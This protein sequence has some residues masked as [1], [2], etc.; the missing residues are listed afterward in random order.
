MAT[1]STARNA[2]DVAIWLDTDAGMA[3]GIS[4]SMASAAIDLQATL[5]EYQ[6]F[7]DCC[8]QRLECGVDATITLN[9]LY[10]TAA[11]EGRDILS[12]WW[13]QGCSKDARTLAIY[14][15]DKNVGSEKWSG[16]FRLEG[17]SFGIDR[18]SASPMPVT[19]VLRPHGCVSHT[20]AAT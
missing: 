5:G 9:V 12:S 1:T 4:G 16:E 7:G 13:A 2:C 11:S 3:T 15:P 10:T 14:L 6:V 8:M 20:T 17:L 18:G 19:A